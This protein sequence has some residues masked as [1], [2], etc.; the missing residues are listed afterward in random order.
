MSMESTLMLALLVLCI[1]LNNYLGLY[2]S[3]KRGAGIPTGS[4]VIKSRD[5]TFYLIYASYV[6]L[7]FDAVASIT[8]ETYALPIALL[9]FTFTMVGI[10]INLVA[11]RDLAEH[12]SPLAAGAGEQKLVKSGIYSKI[13]H[14]IYLSNLSC[15]LGFALISWNAIALLLFVLCLA[16]FHLRIRREE[17]ELVAAFGDEYAEYTRDVPSMIPRLRRR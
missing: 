13:R 11:R 9:G 1:V 3:R 16:A 14:P 2:V 8:R 10:G 15:S 12:W 6:T 5:Y 17:K 7:L 4:G